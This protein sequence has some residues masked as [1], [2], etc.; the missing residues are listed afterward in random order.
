MDMF[1]DWRVCAAASAI[2]LIFCIQ[3]QMIS[4]RNDR[5]ASYENWEPYKDCQIQYGKA[6][7]RCI[8][9]LLEM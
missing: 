4:V 8:A 9:M 7:D 1:D 2:V 3:W 5:I 6:H